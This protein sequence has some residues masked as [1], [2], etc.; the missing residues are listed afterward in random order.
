MTTSPGIRLPV[1][2]TT[3][4]IAG[5]GPAGLAAA[6]EL[7]H[8][9]IEC[10]V[11]EPRAEVSHDRP[12]AK[13]TN[14]RTMEHFRRWGLAREIR[15]AAPVPHGW[16]DR[17]VFCDSLDGTE[18]TSFPGA[19]ALSSSPAPTHAE[20]ALAIPQPVVEEVLRRHLARR[21]P[22]AAEWGSRV[23]A[24]AEEADRVLVTV[25]DGSGA[26]RQVAAR[27]L[28]GCDG[29]GSLVRKEIGA[30][31]VGHSDPRPNFNVVFSAPDLDPELPPAVQYWVVG[32]PHPGL[33]GRLDLRGTWWAIFPGTGQEFGEAHSAELIGGLVGHTVEHTV[34]ASDPWQA[35]M[36]VA[37]RFQTDRVFLVGESAH[38]N[39]PWGGHGFNTSVGD[40]VN[41]GWKI[42][43][44]VQGWGKPALPASY[45]AERR[46][47]VQQ[48]IDAA[49]SNLGAGIGDLARDAEQIQLRKRAEFHSLGLV[50]GYHYGGSPIVTGGSVQRP[51]DLDRYVPSADAGRRLP[52]AWLENGASLYDSL[53]REL[54][55]LGRFAADRATVETARRTA[56][57]LGIPLTIVE[58][59]ASYPWRDRHFL[60]R[61]DQHIA[62]SGTG[63]TPEIIA[64]AVG[65]G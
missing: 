46:P 44:V 39:P 27:Y 26:A 59:P 50:L 24:V 41:I 43:A 21:A 15:A 37:D 62:W 38:L 36:L 58:A 9:G 28:L 25:E 16:S 13:T 30:R 10:L 19:F 65:A 48:T 54:T 53:G 6:A 49:E 61:P 52:H 1:S 8:H 17:V 57:S 33:I 29:P 55:L 31:F 47:V 63:L 18:I 51:T 35:R 23:T 34:L 7:T 11:V 40:A 5:G 22:A 32:G 14:V 42:A 3:V 56:A 4:L 60:V 2:E 12:R 45:E 20:S 64:T